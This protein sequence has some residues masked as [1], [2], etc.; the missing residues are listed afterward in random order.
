MQLYRNLIILIYYVLVI[1]VEV[2]DI[3]IVLPFFHPRSLLKMR[4]CVGIFLSREIKM[5]IYA[6]VFISGDR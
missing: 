1:A 5:A 4:Y 2:S 6:V 3:N